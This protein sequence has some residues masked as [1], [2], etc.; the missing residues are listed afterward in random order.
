MENHIL[1]ATKGGEERFRSND[2]IFFIN[3]YPFRGLVNNMTRRLQNMDVERPFVD[4]TNID[5]DLKVDIEIMSNLRDIENLRTQLRKY[6]LDIIEAEREMEVLIIK[7][8]KIFGNY[9]T[10]DGSAN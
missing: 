10:N 9:L 4:E 1:P 7:D 3:N 5:P 8:K 6:G 2:S